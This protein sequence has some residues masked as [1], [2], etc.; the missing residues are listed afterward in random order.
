MANFNTIGIDDLALSFEDIAEI[1]DDIILN[2]LIAEADIVAAAQKAEAR[3][4]GIFETGI[5]A[6]S[7]TFDRK[8]KIIGTKKEI[9]VYPRGTR[10]DGNSR[11]IAEVAFI[12]EFG[13]K[14]Q[15]GRPFMLKANEK[16]ADAATEAAARVYDDFL[17]SKNL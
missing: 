6:D 12:N 16:S 7:I 5:T 13:K 1:P 8:L 4:L 2:M 15:P 17:K 3:T 9:Y 10:N 14:G 11:E